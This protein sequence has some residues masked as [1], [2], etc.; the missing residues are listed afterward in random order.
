VSKARVLGL[1]AISIGIIGLLCIAIL[2]PYIT[3]TAFTAVA[4]HEFGHSFGLT[5][6][7]NEYC[8][9]NRE[10][11]PLSSYMP[12]GDPIRKDGEESRLL[13]SIKFLNLNT[14]YN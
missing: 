14:E 6:C 4:L 11:T 13:T 3:D 7:P 9:M 12:T 1:G 10:H 2:Q 8:I 5:H